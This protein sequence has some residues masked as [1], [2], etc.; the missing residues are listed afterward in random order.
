MG[1]LLR[2]M[3]GAAALFAIAMVGGCAD[4]FSDASKTQ[5]TA[6]LAAANEVPPVTAEGEGTGQ[7]ALDKTTKVLKWKV[8]YHDLS[9]P[10]T[11]AHFHGPATINI[12][13]GVV[14]PIAVGPSPLEGQAKLTDAQ[15][16]DLMA[17]K[18]YVNI[19]TAKNKGGE[20][21]GQVVMAK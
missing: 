3:T 20:I 5:F 1:K 16:A 6:T 12:S 10:A 2:L 4:D 7:F 15:I 8:K 9:G 17:G 18:W 19:H 21:R 13:A 11:A 14:L